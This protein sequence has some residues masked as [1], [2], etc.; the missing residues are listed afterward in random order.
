M[1]GFRKFFTLYKNSTHPSLLSLKRTQ[2]PLGSASVS[3]EAHTAHPF[4][5]LGLSWLTPPQGG[6]PD[7]P[8]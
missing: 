7:R 8:L 2:L 3:P 4:S 1:Q 5:S 6:P